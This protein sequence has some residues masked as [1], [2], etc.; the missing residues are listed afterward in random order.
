[1][2]EFGSRIYA[3]T[4]VSVDKLA[5][6]GPLIY[7]AP[8]LYIKLTFYCRIVTFAAVARSQHVDLPAV[9]VQT[10]YN[11]CTRP[12]YPPASS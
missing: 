6:I 8:H 5:P 9:A 2:R 11:R 7:G 12:A 10:I 4:V 3:K 1:M